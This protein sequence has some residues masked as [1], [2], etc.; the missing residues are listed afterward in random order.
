MS[1]ADILTILRPALPPNYTVLD[2]I[3]R[4]A[5]GTVFRGTVDGEQVAL[6]V[7]NPA[8]DQ[9][10]L[11]RE[12]DFLRTANHPNLVKIIDAQSITIRGSD[13]PIV[14]YEYLSGGDLV[15]MLNAM[16]TPVDVETVV[17]IGAQISSAIECLWQ[18]RI[19]HRDIK[20][21]NIL[22]ASDD[23][24]VLADFGLARH[25]DL[26]TITSGIQI[27]GT[28]GYMS[29]E[30]AMGRKKLTIHS[31]VFSLGVTLY[32]IA[33]ARHPFN[34]LQ[35]SCGFSLAYKL[36][37][38]RKDLPPRLIRLVEQMM[39]ATPAMRPSNLAAQFLSL[40][41]RL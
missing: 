4:G 1:I 35:P 26:A 40:K 27:I 19:V 11:D 18:S 38:V 37:D 21:G 23:R 39:N 28:H 12:L 34:G 13:C 25:L 33:G 17:E 8:T 9:R 29:P 24:F 41:E 2:Y 32:E 14:A 3:S 7:F 20:P 5:Q 31:D 22:K 36:W 16:S 15:D 6:K 10:R 30:Q